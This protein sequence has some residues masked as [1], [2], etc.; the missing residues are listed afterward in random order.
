MT[1]T[2]WGETKNRRRRRKRRNNQLE[3]ATPYSITGS[4]DCEVFGHS[5]GYRDLAG[6]TTCLDCGIKIFCP[7]CIKRHPTDEN[8]IAI[9]CERHE[10]SAVQHAV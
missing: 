8:A 2:L 6:C 7:R 3:T 10:E 1:Q 4:N 9:L 5:E